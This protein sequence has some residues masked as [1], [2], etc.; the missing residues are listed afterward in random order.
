MVFPN[1]CYRAVLLCSVLT[2]LIHLC[3]MPAFAQIKLPRTDSVHVDISHP[4][5]NLLTTRPLLLVHGGYLGFQ[6]NYRS[7]IDTPF[8]EK[9][10]LQHQLTGRLMLTV[11]NNLPLQVNFWVRRS[12]SQFFRNTADVQVAFN[13]AAFRN[14]LQGMIRSRLLALAPCRSSGTTGWAGWP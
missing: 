8:S 11:A 7:Y 5:K 3:A 14:N 1:P 13:G 10:I 2:L 12:N 9:N 4:F 6:S